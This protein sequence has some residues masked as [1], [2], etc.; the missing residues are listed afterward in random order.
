M[1]PSRIACV[2]SFKVSSPV[3]GSV[4]PKQTRQDP[5]TIFAS[6]LFRWLEVAN[7][8][9]GGVAYTSVGLSKDPTQR[10][11]ITN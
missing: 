5:S 11:R 9:T 8:A 2:L 3:F 6:M 4:T 10:V 1:S 7:F